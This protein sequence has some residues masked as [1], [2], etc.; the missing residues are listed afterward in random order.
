MGIYHPG[1][2]TNQFSEVAEVHLVV[3]IEALI[4]LLY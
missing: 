4:Q 2:L 3:K 1:F